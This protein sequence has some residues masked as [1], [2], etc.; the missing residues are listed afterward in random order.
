MKWTWPSGAVFDVQAFGETKVAE[1]TAEKHERF[2]ALHTEREDWPFGTYISVNV[3]GPLPPGGG[4]RGSRARVVPVA[5][6]APCPVPAALQL[7][8]ADM[9]KA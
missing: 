7:L 2:S 8:D 3:L 4:P 9:E 5:E 6:L 1:M